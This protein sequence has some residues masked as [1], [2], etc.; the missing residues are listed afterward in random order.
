MGDALNSRK[1]KVLQEYTKLPDSESNSATVL[2]I[3]APGIGKHQIARALLA[4]ESALSL[5]VRMCAKLPLPD[6]GDAGRPSIDFVIM[7]IDLSNRDSYM[8]VKQS[9]RAIDVGFFV[10]KL[11][12]V[13]TQVHSGGRGS[14]TVE[15]VTELADS[16]RCPYFC[17][18]LQDLSELHGVAEQL[19]TQ[20][21]QSTGHSPLSFLQFSAVHPT[22]SRFS[23][24]APSSH[25]V[26]S[27]LPTLTSATNS[28]VTQ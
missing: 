10:G 16:C 9:L 3:G 4:T 26:F 17:C 2:I 25:S 19:V 13:L 7:V 12:F 11:C 15:T 27:L 23:V 5:N 14:V 20:I 1:E 24:T 21:Q 28:N 18:N 22:S 8:T 6:V